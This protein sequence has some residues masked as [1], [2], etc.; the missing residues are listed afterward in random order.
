M[1]ITINQD[2]VKYLTDNFAA[3]PEELSELRPEDCSDTSFY[4]EL[5]KLRG[6]RYEDSLIYR[7]IEED[8]GKTEADVRNE[9]SFIDSTNPPIQISLENYYKFGAYSLDVINN[10]ALLL[11]WIDKLNRFISIRDCIIRKI[12]TERAPF[13]SFESELEEARLLICE[14]LSNAKKKEL[15]DAFKIIR[16][17]ISEDKTAYDKVAADME[18][19]LDVLGF[20][21]VE[22]VAYRFYDKSAPE[23]LEYVSERLR[24]IIGDLLNTSEA[25]DLLYNKYL[26]YKTLE[27]LYGRKIYEMSSNGGYPAFADAFRENTVLVKKNNFQSLGKE[28]EKIEITENTDLHALYKQISAKG[29]YFILEE[30]IKPHPL[31][32]R[33]NPDSVNTVRIVTFMDR[34]ESVVLDAFLRIGRK[35]SF[36]DNGGSGGIFVHV[37][38]EKGITDSHGIDVYGGVYESNPDH[39][40]LFRGISMPFW[41]DALNTAKE[42]A[43]R[44]SGARYVGWDLACTDDNHWIIVEGNCMTMYIGQQAT[45]G[46]GKRKDLLKAI[47]YD[48]LIESEQPLRT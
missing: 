12:E 21:P 42:A 38:P 8:C 44:I 39:N 29:Q 27:P 26:T 18:F 37:D 28:T 20:L 19:S 36:V 6:R 13:P 14:L 41:E 10:E 17:D 35:N 24:I 11:Q 5:L 45:V 34:S 22:Y 47:H 33:L 2:R 7:F 40:Y 32:R 4:I 31:F 46:Y 1:D 9:L 23:R 30:M 43:M 25:I 15:I 3:T 48:E 16:P